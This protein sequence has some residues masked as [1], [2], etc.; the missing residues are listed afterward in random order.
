MYW[1]PTRNRTGSNVRPRRRQPDPLLGK[2]V[3][4]QPVSAILDTGDSTSAAVARLRRPNQATHPP[5]PRRHRDRRDGRKRLGRCS[6][7]IA[8]GALTRH[9]SR[10]IRHRPPAQCGNGRSVPVDLLVGR[11]VT[12]GYALDIDYDARRFRLLPSGRL[13]FRGSSAPLRITGTW[14]GYVT[15]IS[16]GADAHFAH[17]DRYRRR[18]CGLTA[19]A[20]GME[21]PA[22][23]EGTDHQHDRL[24][25]WRS[26]RWSISQSFPR[27]A[28]RHADRT[29]CRDAN[30][31][32]HR[33]HP[34][35]RHER[36]HRIGLPRLATAFC[37]IQE[38]GVWC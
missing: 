24:W 36:A 22:R 1:H 8:I 35:D 13:P 28:Q 9:N 16:V 18:R 26:R 25:H 4:G 30:R 14:P 27:R 10:A 33:L 17:P 2:T 32:R 29:Q 15:E 21:S 6:R 19:A 12:Q 5:R 31:T 38:P 7:E 11:D 3:D 23:S 34:D 37:S 20:Y